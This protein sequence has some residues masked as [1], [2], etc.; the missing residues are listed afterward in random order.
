MTLTTRL[1]LGLLGGMLLLSLAVSPV[2]AQ[3]GGSPADQAK[4][5]QQGDAP[6]SQGG[7]SADTGEVIEEVAPDVL[8]YVLVAVLIVGGGIYW[9]T[10]SAGQGADAGPAATEV[11]ATE[12]A[13]TE[14]AVTEPAVTEPAATE[15][16]ATE[17][18][19]TEEAVAE[20]A[21]AGDAGD[22]DAGDADAGDADAAP[23][24]G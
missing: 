4:F 1:G 9:F 6:I 17:P 16:A 7:Q 23:D 22:A 5:E 11:E 2:A 19:A 15:P 20:A 18:A 14:P 10:T 13:V 3:S 24:D 8:P 12:P 21:D